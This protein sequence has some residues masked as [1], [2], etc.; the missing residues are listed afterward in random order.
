MIET[1]TPAFS[2]TFPSCKIRLRPPPPWPSRSH[3]S[4]WNVLP[5]I[6]SIPAQISSWTRKINASMRLESGALVLN[7]MLSFEARSSERGS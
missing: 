7:S 4:S 5:S 6:A 3:E 1:P 2:N